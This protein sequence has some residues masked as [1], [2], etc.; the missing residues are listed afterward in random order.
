MKP[1]HTFVKRGL[2]SLADGAAIDDVCETKNRRFRLIGSGTPKSSHAARCA[3]LG[4]SSAVLL[5]SL[6]Y[7]SSVYASLAQAWLTP[8]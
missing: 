2:A 6:E 4:F 8:F 3:H 5:A 7:H 1:S